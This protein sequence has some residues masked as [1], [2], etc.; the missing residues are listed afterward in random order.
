MIIQTINTRYQ[1]VD[2]GDGHFMIKGNQKYCPKFMRCMIN[3]QPKVGDR[4]MY[5]LEEGPRAGHRIVSS[6]IVQINYNTNV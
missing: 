4:F 1:L 6:V 5:R 3:D 2:E